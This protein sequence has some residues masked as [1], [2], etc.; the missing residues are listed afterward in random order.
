MQLKFNFGQHKKKFTGHFKVKMF[1]LVCV[2]EEEDEE[3]KFS[4]QD[5]QQNN[6]KLKKEKSMSDLQFYLKQ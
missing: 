1:Y 3:N 6:E 2:D 4:Q 5:D